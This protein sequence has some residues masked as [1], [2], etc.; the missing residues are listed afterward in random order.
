MPRYKVEVEFL[1][2]RLLTQEELSALEGAVLAQVKE[3]VDGEGNDLD[4]SV[5][6]VKGTAAL[7]Y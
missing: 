3:P 4:V 2:D 6:E 5:S 7:R 1:T